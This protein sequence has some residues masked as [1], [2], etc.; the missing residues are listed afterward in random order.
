[1]FVYTQY[2]IYPFSD[3]TLFGQEIIAFRAISAFTAINTS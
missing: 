2:D 3:T 1:M